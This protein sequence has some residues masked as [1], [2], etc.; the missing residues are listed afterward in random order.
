MEHAKT[1]KIKKIKIHT[2]MHAYIQSA[3]WSELNE[4]SVKQWQNEWE[5]SSKVVITNGGQVEAKN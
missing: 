3:V 4:R 5:R 1:N 2:Y